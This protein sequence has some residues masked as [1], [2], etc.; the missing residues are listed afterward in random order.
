MKQN[1]KKLLTSVCI[2][3]ICF[4][5]G[6]GSSILS[7]V[8]Y[9]TLTDQEEMHA[10]LT[11]ERVGI[12]KISF[13]DEIQSMVLYADVW[14]NGE[15]ID[16]KLLS[17]SERQDNTLYIAVDGIKNEEFQD[18]GTEW[19]MG[20]KEVPNGS[21]RVDP[22]RVTFDEHEQTGGG[23]IIVFLGEEAGSYMFDSEK[24]YMLA[25]EGYKFTDSITYSSCE[26]FVRDPEKLEEYDYAVVL[27]MDTFA[28]VEGAKAV[29]D[30]HTALTQQ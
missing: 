1:T 13:A 27:R 24:S 9:V 17:Y 3:A 26:A 11:A 28:D 12:L 10:S 16:S 19:T 14:K 25:I 20:W 30:A 21:V 6:C 2:I 15:R 7:T 29:F 22:I 4:I 23:H 8:K 18:I 5:A